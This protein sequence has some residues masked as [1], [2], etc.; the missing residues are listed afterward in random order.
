MG[1]KE[2][3]VH[4]LVDMGSI[5]A[6]KVGR[7]WR[8]YRGAVENYVG[9]KYVRKTYRRVA[10]NSNNSRGGGFFELLGGNNP[11]VNP[12]GGLVRL[13][14]AGGLQPLEYKPDGLHQIPIKKYKPIRPRTRPVSPFQLEF[15]FDG[16]G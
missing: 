1:V 11:P 7:L 3:H 13:P 4:Y 14:D 16:A 5:E 12:A 2:R 15:C 6:F 10:C 8:F 9:S